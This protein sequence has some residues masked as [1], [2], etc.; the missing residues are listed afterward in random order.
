[1]WAGKTDLTLCRAH[2]SF[3]WFRHVQAHFVYDT[4]N[5]DVRQTHWTTKFRL[6]TYIY[7]MKSH[8]CIITPTHYPKYD[9]QQANP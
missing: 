9:V 1:M 4:D 3:Y 2:M 6:L 7:L 8:Y 5:Q